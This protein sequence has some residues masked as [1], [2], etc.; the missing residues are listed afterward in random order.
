[1][2]NQDISS[3]R[4]WAHHSVGDATDEASMEHT[5]EA[6]LMERADS[7]SSLLDTNLHRSIQG[8]SNRHEYEYSYQDPDPPI[9]PRD[10]DQRNSSNTAEVLTLWARY[11]GLSPPNI[12][13]D[14]TRVS[15][16]TGCPELGTLGWITSSS[17]S[18]DFESFRAMIRVARGQAFNTTFPRAHG[19]G[20][21]RVSKT[22][23]QVK[24]KIDHYQMRN[25]MVSTS[26]RDVFYANKRR[27]LHVDPT[28][29]ID[30]VECPR[31]VMELSQQD[32]DL[33]G[34]ISTLAKSQDNQVLFA[35]TFRGIV[36]YKTL[37]SKASIVTTEFSGQRQVPV[38]HIDTTPF[39]ST[40]FMANN[41]GTLITLDYDSNRI[42]SRSHLYC[43][44]GN[45]FYCTPIVEP[46][47]RSLAVNCSTSLDG[48][49]RLLVGDFEHL[50]L[51]DTRS[52]TS[53]G[54]I[55]AIPF[56]S[57]ARKAGSQPCSSSFAVAWSPFDGYTVA[58]GSEDGRIL[59][60]DARQWRVISSLQANSSISALHFTQKPSRRWVREGGQILL[61]AESSDIVHAIDLLCPAN[62]ED[63]CFMGDFGGLSANGDGTISILNSDRDFG[64]LMVWDSSRRKDGLDA[65][66]LSS[67]GWSESFSFD[68]SRDLDF[69]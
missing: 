63:L 43:E 54:V 59:I 40:A 19:I 23:G 12:P 33:K 38:N 35:G 42:T 25:L 47:K 57:T 11:H 1:M 50:V 15:R 49:L 21:W 44:G 64:G 58:T 51:S 53:T 34:R 37:D 69:V 16:E 18:K 67:R 13:C 65:G 14:S 8:S 39:Q 60:W 56:S 7:K 30:S 32:S 52:N 3:S 55:G 10:N 29:P 17:A 68:Q 2:S 28:D 62:S 61:A 66:G 20:N 6:L 48:R 4:R 41:D 24:S 27:V 5:R 31:T 26:Q 45:R 36:S 9:V 22:L 46:T